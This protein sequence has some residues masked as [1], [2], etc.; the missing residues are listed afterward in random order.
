DFATVFASADA[1]A[2]EKVFGKCRA[3]HKLVEGENAVGPYLY[4]VV[5]RATG[6][7]SGFNYSGALSAATDAWTPEALNAFLENPAGYA[8]GTTMSF[9]GLPDV[10]DRANLIAYL[11]G[12]DG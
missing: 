6:A 10:E 11:D 8:P 5:G 2:G 12:T 3:C 1:G 9:R 4:G 7:A